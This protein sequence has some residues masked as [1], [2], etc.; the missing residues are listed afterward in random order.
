MRRVPDADRVP[1]TAWVP[2]AHVPVARVVRERRSASNRSVTDRRSVGSMG[3]SC[4]SLVNTAVTI[5]GTIAMCS[6]VGARRSSG[7]IGT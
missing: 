4:T 3:C 2:T 6:V 5:G 1:S 7:T